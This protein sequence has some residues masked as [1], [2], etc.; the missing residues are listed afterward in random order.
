MVG[1]PCA[2]D[3]RVTP[4]VAPGRVMAIFGPTG[5]GK[6]AVALE[7]ARRLGVRVISCDSMQLYRGLPVLTNHPSPADLAACEHALVG[8]VDPDDEWTAAVYAARAVTEVD[9]DLARRG[10]ALV[11]GGTGL[12]LRAALAPLAIPTVH[13]PVLRA[14]LEARALAEGPEA[15][16]SELTRLDP[17][18]AARIHPRNLRRV[19]RALEVVT[20]AGPGAWSGRDDLWQPAFRH[21]TVIVALTMERP[22][23]DER[24]A[25]RA[26]DMVEGGAVDEVRAE[27]ARRGAAG[28]APPPGFALPQPGASLTPVAQLPP[29]A[30][31]GVTKAIGY[32][33]IC[34]YL[35]GDATLEQT[36]ERLT[37]ATRRYARRQLTWMRRLTDAAIIDVSGRTSADVAAEV[38]SLASAKALAAGGAKPSVE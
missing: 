6:T 28:A 2:A 20:A 16:Y 31:R 18:A 7:V 14:Q 21:P 30:A 3:G 11:V 4:P 17:G 37:V 10:W 8:V 33:E 35:D 22:L 38:V 36:V 24:I 5:V 34:A 27:R 1:V 19:I 12:Y 23:L 26:R 13:D 25:A 29:T 32:A 9:A 15:L